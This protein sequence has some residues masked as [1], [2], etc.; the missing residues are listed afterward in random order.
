MQ[1]SLYGG[2]IT[3]VIPADWRDVSD[4][5]QVPDQECWQDTEGRL[6]VVEI[7]ERQPVED[8]KAAAYFFEDL[9]DAD[10]NAAF[11]KIFT[12]LET[13]PAIVA[14][15]PESTQ[16]CLGVGYQRLKLGRDVD[17]AGNPRQQESRVIRVE[18]CVLRL[19]EKDTDVLI[20][21]STPGEP[22]PQ[23]T[24]SSTLSEVFQHAVGAFRIND[25][26]LFGS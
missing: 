17:I 3:T 5:R 26:G 16:V 8:A 1:R 9:A 2:A 18:V 22:N 11:E 21:L 4:I 14:G 20:T 24:T 25:W 23:E 7:L 15:L 12:P 13:A 19:V 10:S 6:L